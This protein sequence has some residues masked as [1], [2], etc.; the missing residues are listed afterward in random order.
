LSELVPPPPAISSGRT[1]WIALGALAV[2]GIAFFAIASGGIGRN[3]VYYWG[4]AEVAKAGE[5]AVGAT[6]RLGGQVA[7]GTVKY[8]A[9]SSSLTFEVRDAKAVVKVHS[10]GVPPQMF[11]E[12]VGVV[13]EGT[14]TAG[15]VFE[16]N[17]LM[18]SHDNEYRPPKAGSDVA[19]ADLMKSTSGL[20]KPES[21]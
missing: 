12:N 20:E 3:L 16:S 10:S 2:A 13:V 9:D 17:R 15:G 4:P 11:R 14:M 8:S 19:T 21:R 7:P 1:K 5:K 6:I 18:V